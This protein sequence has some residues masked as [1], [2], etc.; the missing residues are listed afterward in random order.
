MTTCTIVLYA[1][2]PHGEQWLG[3]RFPSAPRVIAWCDGSE[4]DGVVWAE[5]VRQAARADGV[6]LSIG[7]AGRAPGERVAS[8][9]AA[10]TEACA[11][12][13]RMG[14]DITIAHSALI[15]RAA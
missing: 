1:E 5:G 13:R 10:A 9:V 15:S 6:R 11:H 12:A 8:A 7:V 4:I 14:G 2:T 3:A